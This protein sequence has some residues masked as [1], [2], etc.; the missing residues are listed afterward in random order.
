MVENELIP[1]I[2]QRPSYPW[3]HSANNNHNPDTTVFLNAFGSFPSG[4]KR[5]AER[6]QVAGGIGREEGTDI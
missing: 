4:K 6:W 5:A 2:C 1:C 3:K